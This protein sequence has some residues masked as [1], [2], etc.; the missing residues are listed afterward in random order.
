MS[1]PTSLE[2][3]RRRATI[4]AILGLDADKISVQDIGQNLMQEGV[5]VDL[6]LSRWRARQSLDLDDLGLP[7]L[8]ADEAKAVSS[9]FKLGEKRLLPDTYFN[10]LVALERVIYRTL[11][12]FA[13]KSPWGSFVPATAFP[14]WKE[15][16][17]QAAADWFA[18]RDEIVRDYP[19]IMAL[20]REQYAVASRRAYRVLNKM[21]GV[22][23]AE[24]LGDQETFVRA[25]WARIKAAI[26]TAAEIGASF[27]LDVSYSLVPLPSLLAS[28]SADASETTVEALRSRV[29]A[30]EEAEARRRKLIDDM[31]REV[32]AQARA[33]KEELID[34]FLA[35]LVVQ[36]RGL[37]YQ[38]SV[39]TLTGLEGKA[40]PHNRSLGALKELIGKVQR[41][42]F[43]GDTEAT[44]MMAQIQGL[45]DREPKDRTPAEIQRVLRAIGTVARSSL[46]AIG[47]EPRSARD[48]GIADAPSTSEI[49][50][51]RADLG[52]VV[53]EGGEMRAGRA[54]ELDH[55]LLAAPTGR[56]G[57]R[58]D[59]LGDE[60]PT[61]D[62]GAMRSR[63][64]I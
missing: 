26:P 15:A 23:D 17:A 6:S 58:V 49:R 47:E 40:A 31:N 62:G 64:D 22:L 32:L 35:G 55:D 42:N 30:A 43:F 48:V 5:I 39:D 45:L 28:G 19:Q 37:I 53:V 8:T 38:V 12:K 27:R 51:A 36:L 2:N 21:E 1:D 16:H 13:F 61:G 60:P 20:L 34:S 33:K 25:T 57:R 59:L 29:S 44:A 24:R 9:I 18:L 56:R 4:A 50:A 14:A 10:R 52:L 54:L 63:R 46:I 7:P 11:E 3:A 41:L